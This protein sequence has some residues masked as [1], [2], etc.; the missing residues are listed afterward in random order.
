MKRISSHFPARRA[1]QVRS[2]VACAAYVADHHSVRREEE[3]SRARVCAHLFLADLP[4]NG[5]IA[6]FV[7]YCLPHAGRPAAAPGEEA[8]PRAAGTGDRDVASNLQRPAVLM[9]V[10]ERYAED[11]SP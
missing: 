11:T 9:P 6:L 2:A 1:E 8:T 7:H 5:A 4:T 10:L 3:A